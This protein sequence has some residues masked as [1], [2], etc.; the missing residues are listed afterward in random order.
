[1]AS[2]LS[3]DAPPTGAAAHSVPRSRS[4]SAS[5][6]GYDAPPA[7]A[8]ARDQGA[9]IRQLHYD[10]TSRIPES[11]VPPAFDMWGF[12]DRM[13]QTLLW[14]ALTD[15]QPSLVTDTLRQLGAQNWYEGFPDS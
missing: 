5:D 14:V 13:A 8:L 11:A 3:H 6:S 10:V 7:G 1:M 4:G 9:F 12:C 15:Q 2:H